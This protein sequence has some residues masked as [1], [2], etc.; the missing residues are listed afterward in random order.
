MPASAAVSLFLM[1]AG[2]VIFLLWAFYSLRR[3]GVAKTGARLMIIGLCLFL[4]SMPACG[5]CILTERIAAMPMVE[6]QES[7]KI[8]ETSHIVI[9]HGFW[10]YW[11]AVGL[12]AVFSGLVLKLAG[13]KPS[14]TTG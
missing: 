1:F 3:S 14:E 11:M 6:G 2:T 4:L 13:G 5:G 8:I 10:V 12:L 9:K 7:K